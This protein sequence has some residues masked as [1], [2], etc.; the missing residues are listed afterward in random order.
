MKIQT[1]VGDQTQYLAREYNDNTMRFIIKYPGKLN[2]DLL[3][4]AIKILVQRVEILHSSFQANAFGTKWIVNKTYSEEKLVIVKNIEEDVWEAAKTASLQAIDYTEET[5]LQCILFQNEAESVLVL[6]VGHMCCDGRDAVYL[7]K[8]LIELYNQLL[9]GESTEQVKIKSGSR[10]I[11]QCYDGDNE[12]L[13]FDMD[14]IKKEKS[15]EV[16]SSYRFLDDGE[17]EACLVMR[18]LSSDAIAKCRKL[19]EH[20]TV[21]DVILSAY[22]RTYVKQMKL[23]NDTP[24]G[25]ASMMDLRRYITGGDSAGVTNLSGP[26]S[27]SLACGI[28]DSFKHTLSTVVE[29]M[30]TLK[31][32]NKAGMDFTLAIRKCYKIIPFP[33]IVAAGKKIYS[34]M[35]IGLTN[36]G[37]LKSEDLKMGEATPE[38][39]CFAG[40]LKKKPALQISASGLDGEVRLCIASEC[41]MEDKKQLEELLEMIDCEIKDVE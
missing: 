12:M 41:T 17:G 21:N 6:L 35:S 39:F 7:M 22:Y 2:A 40:P 11:E 27:T 23:S 30:N 5:Q 1:E 38:D 10:S 28:G 16:K 20:A 25:I 31:N 15:A 37:N 32:D 24:V 8:K 36:I 14:K 26:I 19:V 13:G 9:V 29:Q 33:I 3:N 4:K 18:R 34:N